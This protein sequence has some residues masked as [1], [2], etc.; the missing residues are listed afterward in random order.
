LIWLGIYNDGDTPPKSRY[1]SFS[2]K[3]KIDKV[4]A[5]GSK[6]FGLGT[7]KY[8]LEYSHAILITDREEIKA[9]T[10]LKT[11]DYNARREPK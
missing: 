8:K 5:K 10:M 2:F 3:I 9:R 4:L 6:Y 7:R 11:T 1:G